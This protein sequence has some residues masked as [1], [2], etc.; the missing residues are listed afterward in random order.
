M[1][2]NSKQEKDKMAVN[3]IDSHKGEE[4]K[5]GDVG[6]D[7]VDQIPANSL[8]RKMSTDSYPKKKPSFQ[9]LSV[10]LKYGSRRVERDLTGEDHDGDSLDDLDESHTDDI[11]SSDIL[12]MSKTTDIDPDPS[13]DQD[14][15][16]NMNEGE[17]SVKAEV[18]KNDS[19]QNLQT[20]VQANLSRFK[21]V[22]IESKEPFKRGRWTC[23]DFLDPHEKDSAKVEDVGSGNSSAASSIHYV[24]GVDDP[25]KNPLLEM[26]SNLN[27]ENHQ[28]IEPMPV[29]PASQQDNNS[30]E[31]DYSNSIQH[32][33]QLVQ[34]VNQRNHQS[35][36][37]NPDQNGHLVH[38]SPE[39]PHPP[40]NSQSQEYVAQHDYMT[41]QGQ[42][43]QTN[44]NLSDQ[45]LNMG[46]VVQN[47]KLGQ[48]DS[49]QSKI[50]A[51][52]VHGM[53]GL[54]QENVT[55]DHQMGRLTSP[56]QHQQH[57]QAPTL[58]YQGDVS[59]LTEQHI[60]EKYVTIDNESN[61]K[62]HHNLQSE[63]GAASQ[64]LQHE[65]SNAQQLQGEYPSSQQLQNDYSSQQQQ[66]QNEY[67]TQQLTS[68]YQG[69]QIPADYQIHNSYNI[70]NDFQTQQH[71]QGDFQSHGQQHL[72]P[73]NDSVPG[74]NDL[75]NNPRVVNKVDRHGKVIQSGNVDPIQL[76]T[77]TNPDPQSDSDQAA[78][79]LNKNSSPEE[80]VAQVVI[81][82]DGNKEY[83]SMN[84]KL[85]YGG[86]RPDSISIL[87]KL[88]D[89]DSSRA[90]DTAAQTLLTPPLLEIVSASIQPSLASPSKDEG[91]ER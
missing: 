60:G 11:S 65:Y 76:H 15:F 27:V 46:S 21:V 82:E 50:E 69:S 90:K 81:K 80:R 2:D 53:P 17:E 9:I 13:S 25:A 87:D 54:I 31:Y 35:I 64:Q 28:I 67:T 63:Y 85:V 77:G 61:V 59:Q 30:A 33:Q 20:A 22:K 7:D 72:Q 4:G 86:S 34:D 5:R 45:V 1:A 48:G 18:Q 44:S 16:H 88:T 55:Q 23:L 12:D 19:L 26:G 74:Q 42:G 24:P 38:N 37:I 41:N 10:T 29:Y 78:G 14:L 39:M 91:S 36:A 79:S 68:D 52:Q 83:E 84:D 57:S 47:S 32:Q 62:N 58:I 66:L 49:L 71:L 89:P 73:H 75:I 8:Q 56:D 40:V 43:V 3:S 51:G 70:Q 6:H